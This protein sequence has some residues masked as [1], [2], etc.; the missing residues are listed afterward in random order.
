MFQESDSR[1]RGGSVRLEIGK[2]ERNDG[3]DRTR[4][5]LSGSFRF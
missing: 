3:P 2:G 4:F 1:F 5:S